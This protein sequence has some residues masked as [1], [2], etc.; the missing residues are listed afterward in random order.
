MDPFTTG[1]DKGSVPFFHVEVSEADDGH[2]GGFKVTSALPLLGR[3]GGRERGR[4][5]KEEREAEERAT[6]GWVVQAFYGG[7][8]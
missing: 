4:K 7:C 2:D 3:E 1:R 5:G 8:E 6:V